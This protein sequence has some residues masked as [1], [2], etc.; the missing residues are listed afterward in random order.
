MNPGM[1]D[2]RSVTLDTRDVRLLRHLVDHAFGLSS[3]SDMRRVIDLERVAAALD[4][5]LRRD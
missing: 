2:V 1:S 3:P 5:A 4:E